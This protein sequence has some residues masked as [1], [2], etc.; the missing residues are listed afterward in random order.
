MTDALKYHSASPVAEIILNQPAKHNAINGEMWQRLK[1]YVRKAEAD[2]S[3]KVIV[4]RGEGKHFAAGADI[5]EFEETY[6]TPE[7]AEAY[8]RVMLESLKVLEECAKPTIAMIRGSCVGGGC[9][10]ALACD[11]RFAGATAKFGVTPG[12][13]GLV[14]S[15]ADTRRLAQTVGVSNAKDLLFTGRLFKAGEA[16]ELSLADR[17]FA[18]DQL[19]T[20]TRSFVEEIASTSQWSARATKRTFRMLAEGVSDEAPETMDLMLDAFGGDDFKEGYKAFLE[21]RKPDFPT[22]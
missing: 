3:V 21:K 14:Y 20:E 11:F 13:L 9:S 22:K 19:E 6:A 12:K 17:L 5:S 1:N 2:T 10:I 15:L 4:V 8:T 7:S 18:D 16:L